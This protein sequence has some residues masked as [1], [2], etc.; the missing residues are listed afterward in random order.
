MV[1]VATTGP[2][3]WY[4]LGEVAD[5][6]GVWMQRLA[7]GWLVWQLTRSPAWLGI[8]SFLKF[9]PTIALGL[10]GGVLADRM[11]RRVLV[12]GMQAIAVLKAVVITV[13]LWSGDLSIGILVVIELVIGTGIALSQAASRTLVND[14]VPSDR[15]SSAIALDSVV[16]N[17][18]TMIGPAV[19]GAVMLA[20]DLTICFAVIAV[21]TTVHLVVLFA[22]VPDRSFGAPAEESMVGAIVT[23]TRYALAHPGI[24]PM[25]AL[26]LAFTLCAR[27][28]I[29][30]LPAYAGGVLHEGVDA[31]SLL[32]SAVGAGAI[33]S[34]LWLASRRSH[35]GLC[36]V[37][38]RGMLWMGL[39][40]IAFA[41]APNLAV[42]AALALV[43]GAGMTVRAAGIQTLIQL[44]AA[45]HLRGR[46]LSFYG[47]V[48]NGGV[49]LGAALMGALAEGIGLRWA[50]F[51]MSLVSL[52]IWAAVMMRR[53][54]IQASLEPA[55]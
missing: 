16:F 53:R 14:L 7:L 49:A 45:D 44:A 18:S 4:L 50:I 54:E 2:Y 27:P 25:L 23:A 31:V 20:F 41:F 37:V 42:A 55:A 38:L 11:S 1:A 19:A 39:A 6:L 34:G 52:A 17:V 33:G 5:T 3:S 36:R 46:V 24:G 48:L 13:L 30:M 28:L 10:I 12:I 51:A 43:I 47:L 22:V 40:M 32:T 35:L 8:L 26:H 29:E 9:A 15:L 21:L